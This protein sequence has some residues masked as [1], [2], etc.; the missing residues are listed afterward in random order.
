LISTSFGNPALPLLRYDTGDLVEVDSENDC[1]CGMKHTAI[2][3]IRGRAQEFLVGRRGERISVAALNSHTDAFDQVERFRYVQN[4]PGKAVLEI[5]RSNRF[6]PE[7]ELKIAREARLRTNGNIDLAIEHVD[8]IPLT[9]AGK[10][11]FV[12]NRVPELQP[13]NEPCPA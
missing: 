6:T 11:S 1:S 7:D 3:S 4:E 5:V 9:K 13:E 2:K 10:F 12:V 8:A